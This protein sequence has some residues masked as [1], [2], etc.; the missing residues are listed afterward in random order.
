M[1]RQNFWNRHPFWSRCLVWIGLPIAIGLILCVAALVN[2]LPRT[3]GKLQVENIEQKISIQ[4]DRYS[5]PEISA[6]TD[7]DAYFAL[8]FVHAQ[9]RFWQMEMNRRIASGRLSEILGASALGSDAFMRRLGLVSNANKIWHSMAPTERKILQRYVDGVNAGIE[10]LQV[11]PIE[12]YLLHYR[13]ERWTPVDSLVLMQAMAWAYSSNYAVELTR[14]ALIQHYGESAAEHILPGVVENDAVEL[15]TK[16]DRIQLGRDVGIV[17]GHDPFGDSRRSIGSNAWAVSGKYT[18]S[19]APILASD[20]HLGT[21]IPAIWY[22]ASLHGA[23]LDVSGATIPG[24]PFVLIGRNHDIAWGIT[25]AMADTQDAV[26]ELINPLNHNQ[27]K[28]GQTYVDMEVH[29]EEI[30]IRSDFLRPPVAPVVIPIRR[31][32]NGPLISDNGLYSSD[33]AFSVRWSGDDDSGGTFAA[34]V[35]LNYAHNW[36]EFRTALSTYV[37]P[38]NNFVYADRAGNVG[39]LAPGFYPLRRG[40]NGGLPVAG[41]HEG[42]IWAGALAPDEA[43]QVLN[44]ADGIVVAA[45]Q[46]FVDESYPHL[47]TVDWAPSYRAERIRAELNRLVARGNG[48]LSAADMMALQSDFLTPAYR[49]GVLKRMRELPPRSEA[50]RRVLALLAK[51]D[52][53]MSE[54]SAAAAVFAAWSGQLNYVLFSHLIDDKKHVTGPG[55]PLPALRHSDNSQFIERVLTQ[56]AHPWCGSGTASDDRCDGFMYSALNR[57]IHDLESRLGK[58]E[59]RWRWG[60]VHAVQFA[61]F[62]FS[63]DSHMPY[64]PSVGSSS[65]TGWFDRRSAQ[66]GGNDTVNVATISSAEDT[67]FSTFVAPM[68]RQVIDLAIGKNSSFVLGTG[69]SGNPVS[70]HYDD[71]IEPFKRSEYLPMSGRKVLEQ[72]ILLPATEK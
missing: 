49:N 20:P 21:P 42:D 15:L 38:I 64:F 50:Q 57:A 68:Y 52:G 6:Q 66:G 71:L 28:V 51:W 10:K 36:N 17:F 22:L 61:H 45:N 5:V 12:V 34:Y 31:T 59:R 55:D 67:Q 37:A 2:S 40:G 9:D 41:W 11:F 23:R 70:P 33:L 3:S 30:R 4:R 48:K 26:I 63:K 13:P 7:G 39:S 60:Q 56:P 43:P 32:R 54:D 46:K 24:L 35:R 29:D 1:L 18:A 14:L 25:N 69:Q 62:P 44:P 58:D 72:L 16:L 19:G 27:Y 53:R 65:F 8:G 47:I